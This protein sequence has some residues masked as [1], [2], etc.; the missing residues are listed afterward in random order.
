MIQ[1]IRIK[2][3]LDKRAG[4]L[5]YEIQN[6]LKISSVKKIAALKLYRLEGCD[7]KTAQEFAQ[8]VLQDL[9]D[10]CL[11]DKGLSNDWTIIEVG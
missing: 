3:Q 2:T 4:D 5:L 9:Q 1:E 6:T 7:K 10:E 11:I 8:L